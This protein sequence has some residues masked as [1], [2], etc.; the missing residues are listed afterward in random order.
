MLCDDGEE[1]GRASGRCF[2]ERVFH[3]R[4]LVRAACCRGPIVKLFAK[5]GLLPHVRAGSTNPSLPMLPAP[6]EPPP[7][8]PLDARGEASAHTVTK[9][10]KSLTGEAAERMGQG[11]GAALTQ[12]GS[13]SW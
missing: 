4:A 2:V 8:R 7:V 13:A 9:Y 5:A 11:C 12:N 10:W 6:P 3:A 1:L